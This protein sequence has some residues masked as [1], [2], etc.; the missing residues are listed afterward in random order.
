MNWLTEK[1]SNIYQFC[2]GDINKFVLLQRKGVY[3]YEYIDSWERFNETSLLD[4]KFFY[5]GLNLEDITDED[6][7]YAQKMFEE[8]KLKKLSEY[9]DL[10]VQCDTLLLADVFKNF[11]NK[12]L[13]YTNLVLLIFCLCQD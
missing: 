9:H 8:F 4:K 2:N 5:I 6:Y 13:K 7:E 12:I 11:R 10:H 1:F 3:P